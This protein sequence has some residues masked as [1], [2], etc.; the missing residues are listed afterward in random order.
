MAHRRTR[1]RFI[2]VKKRATLWL[3]STIETTISNLAAASVVLD[4]SFTFSE[5]A[6]I[7]RVR[8]GFWVASD[9]Q[10]GPEVV[11]GAIGM[12]IVTD[13]ALAIG[14]TAVPTPITDQDSESWFL[15]QPFFTDLRFGTA[16]GLEYNTYFH[17][18]LESKAMRKVDFGKSLVVVVENSSATA[19]MRYIME[20]RVLVKLHS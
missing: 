12:A 18:P 13:E 20:F 4:Q 7:V 19:G 17:V 3:G 16:V 9:Q 15:W 2:E 10:A 11:P 6:T 1:G 5:P 14:V 8:G